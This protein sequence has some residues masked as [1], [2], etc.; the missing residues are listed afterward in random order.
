MPFEPVLVAFGGGRTGTGRIVVCAI[1]SLAAAVG[2]LID[3]GC[4][5]MVRRRV[6]R[7][8]G[9]PERPAGSRFY[10]LTAVAGLLPVPFSIVRASLVRVRPS[11]VTFAGIVAVTR[12]PRYLVTVHAWAMLALPEWAGWVFA[13]TAGVIALEI[14]HLRSIKR[15]D[16][17]EAADPAARAQLT[18]G[19]PM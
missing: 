8:S 2:A 15:R 1:G 9:A 18:R 19:I 10:I 3:A 6:Q 16:R 11:P 5:G 7:L 13:G 4:F 12:F 17:V 14:A